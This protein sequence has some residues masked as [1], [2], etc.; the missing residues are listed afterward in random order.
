MD[1]FTKILEQ[2]G[3][4]FRLQDQLSSLSNSNPVAAWLVILV[5]AMFIANIAITQVIEFK[6]KYFGQ[7]RHNRLAWAG[8]IVGVCLAGLVSAGVVLNLQQATAAVPTF[9]KD[10]DIVIG[11]PLLLKWNYT[12]K[13]A[14]FEIQNSVDPAFKLDVVKTT[15]DGAYFPAEHINGKRFWR[16]REVDANDRPVSPWSRSIA[17]VQ[18]ATSL[19]RIRETRH[20]SVYISNSLN[21]AFFKF[22]VRKDGKRK[23]KGYEIAIIDEIMSKLPH[24]LD[25]KEPLTYDLTPVSWDELLDAPRRGLADII[26]ST[27]TSF[28]ERERDFSIKFS[29][30]YYCTTQSLIYRSPLS[31]KSV[32]EMIE[33]KKVG[34]QRGT[35]SQE[36]MKKFRE[37]FQ[38]DRK[39]ELKDDYDQAKSMVDALASHIIDVGLTDTPFARA[40]QLDHGSDVL[41][42]KELTKE[43]DFPSGTEQQRRVEKYAMAV[44]VGENELI[45]AI[46]KIVVEMGKEK[47]VDLL[48]KAAEEF[49]ETKGGARNLPMFDRKSDPSECNP[50]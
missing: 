29:R 17:V 16:V 50:G 1:F 19:K 21:E 18:Y 28:P 33:K 36:I 15:G 4:F 42:L 23:T 7:W 44:R 37:E 3:A 41:A 49:Y 47:L 35:T 31:S 6:N 45:D 32:R 10:L 48:E 34:V 40:A 46:D 13:N 2:F 14:R 5:I 25:I 8:L 12:N 43:E 30:S 39:F 22:D 20:V 24:L 9:D 11:R 38:A 26:V 27:I